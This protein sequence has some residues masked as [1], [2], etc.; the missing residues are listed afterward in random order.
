MPFNAKREFDN[1]ELFGDLDM[2]ERYFLLKKLDSRKYEFGFLFSNTPNQFPF[3]FRLY[4]INYC[5]SLRQLQDSLE[6]HDIPYDFDDL[7]GQNQGWNFTLTI[8]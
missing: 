4:Y 5:K 2:D 6:Y 8:W 3:K 1:G 7:R